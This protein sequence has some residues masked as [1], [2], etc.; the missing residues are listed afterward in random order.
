VDCSIIG[1]G[2]FTIT[3]GPGIA[4]GGV[5]GVNIDVFDSPPALINAVN[6]ATNGG[7]TVTNDPL[8]QH[9]ENLRTNG[10]NGIVQWK[11]FH[12]QGGQN[13]RQF[14]VDTTGKTDTQI[15]QEIASKFVGLGLGLTAFVHSA[16]E[17]PF[18]S[19]YPQAFTAD[20]DFVRIPNQTDQGVT[21]IWVTAVEGQ[22]ITIEDNI[23][24]G[25]VPTLSTLGMVLLV[26]LLMLGAW[27]L[28]RRR[29][30]QQA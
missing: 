1:E 25:N 20:D 19:H 12:T 9:L 24:G 17:A 21:E 2:G 5:A 28:H 13:P 18:H 10:V 22:L 11:V 15:H 27:F 30:L 14:T 6:F 23:P 26:V 8:P 16:A 3:R 29:P 7:N 4:A